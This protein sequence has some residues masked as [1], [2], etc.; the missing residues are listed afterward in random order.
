M[1]IHFYLL[2]LPISTTVLFTID[3]RKNLKITMILF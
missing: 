2:Q 3:V 1:L